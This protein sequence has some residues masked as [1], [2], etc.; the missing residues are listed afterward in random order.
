MCI[1]QHFT[2]LPDRIRLET[3]V[4]MGEQLGDFLEEK[5]T[6]ENTVKG[7]LSRV[8]LYAWKDHERI[9]FSGTAETFIVK[10]YIALLL[11]LLDGLSAEEIV[12]SKNYIQ[13][14]LVDTGIDV[15]FTPSRKNAFLHIYDAMVVKTTLLG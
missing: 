1:T 2:G 7:C 5:K 4:S 8:Y 12:L 10:G 13:K 6:D 15:S 11:A 3:L 9:F 14:M